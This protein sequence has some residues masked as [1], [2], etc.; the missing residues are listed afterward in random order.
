MTLATVARVKSFLECLAMVYEQ[1]VRAYDP[2]ERS[3]DLPYMTVGSPQLP[4]SLKVVQS[5][6]LD[7]LIIEAKICSRIDIVYIY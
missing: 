7:R 5:N 1:L 3:N 2:I 4:L 6:L